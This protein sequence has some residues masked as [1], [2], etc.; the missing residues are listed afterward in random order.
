MPHIHKLIDFTVGAL[1]I[2]K[3]KVLLVRH[4]ELR[5]WLPVG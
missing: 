5:I 3:N 1:I 4:K 2:C